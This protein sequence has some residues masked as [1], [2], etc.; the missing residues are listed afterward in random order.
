[1]TV[2]FVLMPFFSIAETTMRPTD[3]ITKANNA[4]EN[5]NNYDEKPIVDENDKKIDNPNLNILRRWRTRIHSHTAHIDNK[6][7][8]FTGHKIGYVD[9]HVDVFTR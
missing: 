8:D 5:N 4:M 9:I 2:F 1:M 6:K 7:I 3:K